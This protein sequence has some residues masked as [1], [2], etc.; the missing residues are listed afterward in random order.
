MTLTEI[1]KAVAALM[2][3]SVSDFTVDSQDLF[4]FAVNQVRR[5]AELSHDF[6]FSRK[7]VGLTVDGVTGGSLDDITLS[8]VRA[9]SLSVAGTLN[10]AITGTYVRAGFQINDKPCFFNTSTVTPS[11]IYYKSGD[12]T[13]RLTLWG[14]YD[15]D[16]NNHYS[17]ASGGPNG[18]YTAQVSATGT[19]V[20]T[21]VN[22]FTLKTII[23]IGL[24]DD[25]SNL[26][27]AEWTTVAEGLE[28]QRS[29]NPHFRP[30]YAT[31][32]D[33]RN[34]GPAGL[35]RF[36]LSGNTLFR[37]PKDDTTD[38]DVGLEIYTF[39]NDWTAYT[40]TEDYWLKYG[41]KF[42][43]WGVVCFLNHRFKTF[44]YRQEGNL[45]PPEKTRDEGL[46]SFI[47]WDAAMY[48]SNRRHGR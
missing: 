2:T 40:A 42:L 36:E 11:I 43:T 17:L 20:V 8:A 25:E 33:L 10:A 15:D 35:G 21:V 12:S 19:P 46:A 23:D 3:K 27:P 48:E 18:T 13:W 26:R 30:R 39:Q 34:G 14:G 6:E 28:R 24:Y 32:Q 5:E 37:F 47:E 31:D 9:G 45:P 44:V 22:D 38:V 4:L 29:E 41:H 16:G 1:R 7:V